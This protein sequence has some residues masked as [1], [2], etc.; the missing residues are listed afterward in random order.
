MA[1]SELRLVLTLDDFDGG[2]AFFKDAL[3]LE[4]E[5]EWSN[6]GGRAVLLDAGHASL[7]I[8][9]QAQARAIDEIEVG[10]RVAGPMR[11]AF[12]TTNSES[13]A[14]ALK[15]GAQI[16]GG[17]TVTPWGDRNVRLLGPEGTQLTLFTA[18][19]DAE[20]TSDSTEMRRDL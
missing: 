2:V 3:G 9:D 10:R 18:P 15:A 1:V 4:Q 8:F 6:D 5:A 19:A 17:P 7:E 14:N 20:E 12:R 13:M 16:V 11:I